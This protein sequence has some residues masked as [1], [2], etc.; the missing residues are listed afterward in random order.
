MKLNTFLIA[1]AIVAVFFGLGFLIVPAQLVASYG[2][3][4]NPAGVVVGRITGSTILAFAI[5]FWG[6][7]N[8]K[9]PEALKAVLAAGFFTHG[10]DSFIMLHATWTGIVN[11]LGWSAVAING[12]FALGFAYFAFGK[13]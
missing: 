6:A 2:G 13:R 7:R 5:I 3:T 8:G 10:L 1:A 11:A 9:G 12:A 4:L